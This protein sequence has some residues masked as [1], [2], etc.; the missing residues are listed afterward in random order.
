MNDLTSITYWLDR[1][2]AGERDAA[3]P[4]WEHY[5]RQLLRLA[6]RKLGNQV[7]HADEEDVVQSVFESVFRGIDENRFPQLSDS[8]DLWRVLIVISIRKAFTQAQRERCVKR[9]GG[10]VRGESAFTDPVTGKG[11]I[12]QAPDTDPSPAFAAEVIEQCR[13]RLN[14]LPT[15]QLRH[16][17]TRKLRG[18][19]N[20]EIATNLNCGLRTVERKLG[21]IRD[22]WDLEIDEP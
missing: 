7:R 2:R 1:Y 12:E 3:Q 5:Y 10:V 8:T 14:A 11:G 6:R 16:V 15:P 9:G 4:I 22:L 20:A 17:A 19:T 18:Y 21:L 13:H